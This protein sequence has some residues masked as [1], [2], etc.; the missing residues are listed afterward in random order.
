MTPILLVPPVSEPVSLDEAKAWLRLDT[1]DEDAVV[2]SLI[3]AARCA[4]E[5]ATRRL[6]VTQTWRLSLDGWGACSVASPFDVFAQLGARTVTL[7]LAPVA[8]VAAVRV[9]DAAGSPQT[10]SFAAYQLLGGPDNARLLF[11]AP[12]PTPGRLTAGI[13]IDV[14]AGF[15]APVDVPQ[16][17]RLAILMLVAAWFEDR[18]DEAAVGQRGLPPSVTALVAPFFRPRLA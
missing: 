13:D 7:S 6:L 9:Y 8:S 1:G 14:V 5:A 2:S 16:P 18:G 12:P 17:L 10:L 15:G 3:V 4:I 11:L